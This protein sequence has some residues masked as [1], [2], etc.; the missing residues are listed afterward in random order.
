[1]TTVPKRKPQPTKR[2][3]REVQPTY[4]IDEMQRAMHILALMQGGPQYE[5]VTR[6]S[7]QE[8]PINKKKASPLLD[9]QNLRASA[10]AAGVSVVDAT[11]R[12]LKKAAIQL[13]LD[14]KKG[15]TVLAPVISP[16]E[17]PKVVEPPKVEAPK[18]V[19]PVASVKA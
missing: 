18:V 11:G 6:K 3:I 12:P 10:C 14:A 17:T 7:R 9:Y 1:M 19:V 4:G 8:D 16:A 2:K 15:T 5:P 13:A